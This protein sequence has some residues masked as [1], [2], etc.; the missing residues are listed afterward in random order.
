M[1]WKPV[2]PV[3]P[4]LV[5]Q[6]PEGLSLEEATEMRKRGRQLTPICK[7]GNHFFIHLFQFVYFSSYC[8]LVSGMMVSLSF[9]DFKHLLPECPMPCR[10]LIF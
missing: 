7:L 2:T 10:F 8:G 9:S 5:Q 1:L 4:R 6:A 3:Y